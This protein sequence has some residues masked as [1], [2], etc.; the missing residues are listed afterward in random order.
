MTL[1]AYQS[2]QQ[3]TENPRDTEYRLFGRITGAL[4]DAQKDGTAGAELIKAIDWN[5]QLWSTLA[6]DCLDDRNRLPREVRANIVSLSRFVSKYSRSVAREGASVSPLI[7]INRT[8]MQG[9]QGA[10]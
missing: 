5:R 4:I 3:I 2:T 7:E 1:K 9:L 8:I 6:N 10:A